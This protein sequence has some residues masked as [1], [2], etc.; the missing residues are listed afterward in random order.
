MEWRQKFAING[1]LLYVASTVF[2]CYLS[3]FT[4]NAKVEPETWNALFWIIMLFTATN[5]VAK[6]FMQESEGRMLYYYS[7][8]SPVTVLLSKIIYNTFLMLALGLIAYSFYSVV[9]GNPVLNHSLF[10]LNLF[11]GAIGFSVT[12]TMVSSIASKA[13]N[14]GTLMAIL[15]FPVMIPILL[16]TM[17]VSSNALEGL[18]IDSSINEIIALSSINVIVVVVSL[19]LFPYLW[20]S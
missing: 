19:L 7:I 6:S 14:S 16:M 20:R 10:L 15:G 4:Q 12:L 17:K 2:V 5:A 18:S 11:I 8:A 1:I 13:R 3:F 9:M